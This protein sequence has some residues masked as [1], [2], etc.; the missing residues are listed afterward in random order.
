MD[1]YLKKKIAV[2][3]QDGHFIVGTLRGFDQA[4]NLI[5]T[6]SSERVGNWLVNWMWSMRTA[7]I[8]NL[9]KR[10]L[11]LRSSIDGTLRGFDQATN[12]ILTDS[13]ERVV[14]LHEGVEVV[15][16]GLYIIRGDNVLH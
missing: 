3:T 5:L 13:S 7:S 16:L 4:T 6:D 2:V 15:P 8:S 11:Y 12:L 1:A 9:C 14:S 10:K